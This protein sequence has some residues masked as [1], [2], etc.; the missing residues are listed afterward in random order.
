M[1]ILKEGKCAVC[2]RAQGLWGG[3]V[4]GYTDRC[5]FK[6]CPSNGGHYQNAEQV[7]ASLAE[8]E[9]A[10][11]VAKVF[12]FRVFR[13]F[14]WAWGVAQYLDE[15]AQCLNT[16]LVYGRRDSPP[17]YKTVWRY[18]LDV[19][20]W[21]YRHVFLPDWERPTL[22]KVPRVDWTR[23]MVIATFVVSLTIL[24][25]LFSLHDSAQ[26]DYRR[27]TAQISDL[28][29][30]VQDIE[31]RREVHELICPPETDE[32]G[33]LPNDDEGGR[34]SYGPPWVYADGSQWNGPVDGQEIP[35]NFPA[36][37]DLRKYTDLTEVSGGE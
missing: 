17:S 21:R 3:D 6:D 34:E 11:P 35:A 10:H 37:A 30:R 26:R 31:F 13:F 22:P 18:H 1:S 27:L 5:E 24:L 19:L 28:E 7:L 33:F 15:P 32:S 20:R 23:T 2:G 9:A 4:P 36:L 12:F 14:A 29:V 8:E 16:S 25:L